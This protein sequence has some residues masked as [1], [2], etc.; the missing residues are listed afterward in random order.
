MSDVLIAKLPEYV[1]DH[2][3]LF[4]GEGCWRNGKYINIHRF[5]KND[6]R[7][8]MIEKMPRI[9]QIIL[10]VTHQTKVGCVWYKLDNGKFVVIMTGQGDYF[11]QNHRYAQGNFWE[12]HYNEKRILIT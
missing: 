11:N 2:I 3:K 1:V 4:T 5:P 12:M 7:Y 6:Q 9:K 10:A 8:K